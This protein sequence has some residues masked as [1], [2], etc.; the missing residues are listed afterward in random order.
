M[1]IAS[2][3]TKFFSGLKKDTKEFKVL[4]DTGNGV[5]VFE[6]KTLQQLYPYCTFDIL[7]EEV[8]GTFANHECNPVIE[9]EYSVLQKKIIQ[10][11]YDFGIAFDGDGDR[12][13]FFTEQGMI[14]PD[15]ITAI[16]GTYV[17]NPQEK[18]GYE[19]RTSQGVPAYLEKFEIIPC[20][21]PSGHAYIKKYMQED[22][23]VF[24][25]EKSGHYFYQNLHNTDSSLFTVMNMLALLSSQDRTLQE[26]ADEVI[27]PYV[28]S[29]EI[30]YTVS[31]PDRVLSTIAKEFAE[32][33]VKTIDGV[34]VYG[35]DFFFNV[36][37]SNTENL[38]RINIESID[39]KKVQ[40]LKTALE[41]II[42]R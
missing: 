10:E 37:K 4:V 30:N 26:L 41:K 33:E 22:K 13:T 1:N 18:V 20:L 36:R 12:V 8:D 16:I 5:G 11:D 32:Y 2:E 21:Y 31:N 19:V 3:Y 38:V 15:I 25:G 17:A 42:A 7:F 28:N 6:A 14:P 24:A 29:G 27:G 35:D 9:K 39:K 23:A 40:E 34:S